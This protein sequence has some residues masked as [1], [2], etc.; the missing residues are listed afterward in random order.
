[1]HITSHNFAFLEP[2]DPQ[3]VRLGALAEHYFQG[4][5]STCL[6]KI[7]QFG[8]LLAQLMAARSG[9]YASPN[10][11]QVELLRRMQFAGVMPNNVGILFHQVRRVGNRATHELTG[12][13][14]EALAALKVARELGVWF[15][16]TFRDPR[17]APGPF[18][19]PPDPAAATTLL[20][21][22]LDRLKRA[23]EATQSE[24]E[25]ARSAAEQAARERLSAEERARQER[26]ERTVWEQLA[27]EA[28]AAKTALAQQLQALQVVAAQAPAQA[29]SAIIAQAEAAAQQL[30]IDEATT[31]ALI[32]AQLRNRGW[33]ADT[34]KLRFSAGA[35]P[36]K[37]RNL[38][39]AEWPTLNG[40]ADYALFVGTQCIGVIEAKRRN[41]NVSSTVDQA[42]RYARGLRFEADATPIGGPWPDGSGN[43]FVTPFVFSANGRPYFKQL[44]TE[45]GIW[46]RDVRRPTNLRRA[47]ADW[48]TPDGL[49]AMLEIDIAVAHA[50]LAAQP[51][52]FAFPL[53]PYQQRAIEI[54][55]G[56]LAS[57]RRAM[58]LAMATG[59]GKTKL[60]I[61]LLYRLLAA[62]RFRRV[63]FVVDRNALGQQAAGEFATTRVVSAKTFADIFGLKGLDTVTP[64]PETRVH[65]CTIQGLV[66]RVLYADDPADVPPVD[67]YDLIVVDECHRGYLLDR[68][69]SDAE[70]SFRSQDDYLSKYRRV[71]EH[72]DAV[73]IGLTATPALHTAAI[74][75]EPVFTYSYRE[76]VIDGFLID[77]EPPVQITTALAQAGIRFAKDE[78][79][80]LLDTATGQLDLAKLPDEIH[81]EVDEFNRRVITE[82]FNR[83]V[84]DE[85]ARQIDPSL[86]GKTLIF[87]VTDA[88]ADIVVKVV[89]EAFAAAY[90]TIEDS[91]VQKITG[92]VDGPLQRIR[93]FR[94][95]AQP[96]IAVTVDLL[97]TGIDVPAIENLVFLRRVNSRILYEQMLGRATRRCDENGKETF[98]IFDAV[99][100]YARL[101]HLTQM[102]PVVVNPAIGM[103]QLFDELAQVASDEQRT[104][105]RDQLLVKLRRR[106]QRLGDEARARYEAEAGEKPEETLRRFA[107]EPVAASAAWVRART[108]LG[109]ILDWNPEGGKGSLIPISHHPDQVLE[110][111]SGY[112]SGQK[113]DDF[114]DGFTAFIRSN[115][116][117]SAALAVAVQRPRA[118]TRAELRALRLQLDGQ[119]YSELALRH[120]WSEARHEDVAASI[121][122]FVRQAALGTTLIPFDERVHGAMRR[123]L[124]RKQW[125]PVQKTWLRRIEEQV[126]RE[127]VVD[128]AAL[129]D[130]PFSKDGGFIRLNKVFENR[131]E[132]VLADINEL[133]WENTA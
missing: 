128:R 2:H 77:H 122:G 6:I 44:E 113:P 11:S 51:I 40:P 109:R 88:H 43:A 49:A 117:Q 114:L 35:R 14:A 46:F 20:Q 123:L 5:P 120:A 65:I 100:L 25:R 28:E 47:L 54:V 60:A 9:L 27:A 105:V 36:S 55:E 45:S 18:V 107:S 13:H 24:A 130:E 118:L 91:A 66:K 8:E 115:L 74:F 15:H 96:T 62:K 70:L 3:L 42:Q 59:T 63:C 61:A 48:I 92:S 101:Q 39:I 82:P 95:D 126:L 133:V 93:S 106:L 116:A 132:D 94:N 104:A 30:D 34:A 85:L 68:E 99:D 21:A 67:Q 64:D 50:N 1:M 58:L 75:G 72:F 71:L 98:R 38:A 102:K 57:D 84:A 31:R 33:E 32:D 111:R 89:K 103:E 81:F 29:T 79:V 4:D 121:I 80:E 129:D 83:A 119:G 53:R 108:N 112:G 56:H 10:D 73:K 7:R 97:T 87:A 69:L 37:G 16:R 52:D 131:L 86:P 90:G 23:L 17:F 76:A 127:V 125:T 26:E 110:V 12:N 19:P 22:E 124:A 78:Q 41:K